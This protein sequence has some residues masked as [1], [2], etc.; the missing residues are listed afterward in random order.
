MSTFLP[1]LEL[2]CRFDLVDGAD[3][4]RLVARASEGV[5]CVV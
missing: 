1:N 2:S 5:P 4:D 3:A